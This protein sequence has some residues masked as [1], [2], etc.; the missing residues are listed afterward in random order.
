MAKIFTKSLRDLMK[1]LK[2]VQFLKIANFQRS[3]KRSWR[4][5]LKIYLL[6]ITK[7]KRQVSVW[8]VWIYKEIC[9]MF[10]LNNFKLCFWCQEN[11]LAPPKNLG[12]FFNLIFFSSPFLKSMPRYLAFPLYWGMMQ[13]SHVSISQYQSKCRYM[14]LKS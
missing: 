12:P 8:K 7:K 10:C 1:T 4:D 5:I 9:L 13:W 3:F 14:F 2:D 11:C 6:L